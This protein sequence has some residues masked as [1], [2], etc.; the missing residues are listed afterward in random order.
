VQRTF[1]A[2]GLAVPDA[3][4]ICSFF[5]QPAETYEAWLASL[6]PDDKVA[7]IIEDTNRLELKL[8][9]TEGRLYPGV[10][11][12]LAQLRHDGHTLAI[13][14]NGPDDYVNTFLEAHHMRQ[15]FDI[16]RAR[17]TKYDGK[18]T[19]VHEI[20]DIIPV[21]PAI[22]IGDRHDDIEAAH[23]N[24]AYAIAACYGFGGEEE[25][26]DADRKVS[27]VQDLP[28]AINQIQAM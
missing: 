17:G 28:A 19:M 2:H 13:C 22:V 26:T 10:G 6:V 24:G 11:E 18:I 16:I 25:S 4:E 20:M 27:S 5:G 12:L 21:R 9:A 8:I 3:G 7:Q 1:A 14:S 15:Y 23:Q